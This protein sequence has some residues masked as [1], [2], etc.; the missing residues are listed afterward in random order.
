MNPLTTRLTAMGVG[1]FVVFA[2]VAAR[3]G[4]PTEPGPLRAANGNEANRAGRRE[5]EFFSSMN[6]YGVGTQPTAPTLF[7]LSRPHI[8]TAITTY[9]WN[10][11]RGTGKGTIALVDDGGKLIGSWSATGTPGQGGVPNA[12]WTCTPGVAVPAGT[13]R[14]ADSEPATW[15]QNAQSGGRGMALVKGYPVE[16]AAPQPAGAAAVAPRAESVLVEARVGPA[17]G[18]VAAPGQ[19]AV[20]LPAEALADTEKITITR[21]DPGSTGCGY[22][23]IHREGNGLLRRPATVRFPVGEGVAPAGLCVVHQLVGD[24]AV[25]VPSRFDPTTRTLSTTTLSFSGFGW[26]DWGKLVGGHQIAAG[27]AGVGVVIVVATWAGAAVTGWALGSAALSAW[28][29]KIGLAKA[30]I[31]GLIFGTGGLLAEKPLAR[32]GLDRQ[33]VVRPDPA[34]ESARFLL[35][36]DSNGDPPALF[37][38]CVTAFLDSEGRIAFWASGAVSDQVW[39]DLTTELA[40]THPQPASMLQVANLRPVSVPRAILQ[41]AAELCLSRSILQRCKL[42]VPDQVEVLFKTP[43]TGDSGLWAAPFLYLDPKQ[44]AVRDTS[45]SGLRTRRATLLHEYYHACCALQ[46][47]TNNTY[48]WLEEAIATSLE[49]EFVGCEDYLDKQDGYDWPVAGPVLGSGFVLPRTER[50]GEG[51]RV[52]RGYRM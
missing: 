31:G 9:H 21:S 1:L 34:R 42:P 47:I 19:I 16:S 17:G 11:G 3:V 33:L 24:L 8:I 22:F 10:G 41:A 26:D 38:D 29:G 5:V 43:D 52:K 15:S 6:D 4:A 30:A 36:W 48:P 25:V 2:V 39:R 28:A 44:L 20:E 27:A 14:V 46:R 32:R 13:Y 37:R 40:R 7:T 18:T 49:A 12:Y 35:C 23:Q 50:E 45:G 51:D